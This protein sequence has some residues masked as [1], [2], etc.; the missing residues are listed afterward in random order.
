MLT[1][2][3]RQDD[4][5][6]LLGR[7]YLKTAAEGIPPLAVVAALAQYVQDR[8]LGMDGRNWHQAQWEHARSRVAC[9]YG[10]TAQE[11][12]ICSCTSEAYQRV[13]ACAQ[14]PHHGPCRAA[15]R[16]HPRL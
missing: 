12:S 11:V 5:P 13:L 3:R 15:A 6:S 7:C 2:A 9:V 10:L 1:E 14:H 4:S 8:L 16:G